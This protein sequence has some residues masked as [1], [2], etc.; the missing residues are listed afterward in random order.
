MNKFKIN[1]AKIVYYIFARVVF[2]L[3]YF[4]GS[5]G[6]QNFL[7]QSL[8][9][10]HCRV[11]HPIGFTWLIS[12][13]DAFRTY[14]QSCEPYTTKF[15]LTNFHS[16]DSFICVGA[17]RGWYPL[18]VGTKNSRTKI[19][20][21]E[22]NSRIFDELAENVKENNLNVELI[23]LAVGEHV[24]RADLFMPLNGNEG[25]AT[26]FPIGGAH[27]NASIVES[28]GVTSLDAYF[29]QRMAGFG[30]GLILMDIEG[31]EMK[32]LNGALG[33][34]QEC[35]PSIILEINPEMLEASGSSAAEIFEFLRRLGYEINWIDERGRLES[36]G[37]DNQLPHLKILPPHSGA[38]YL[39]SIGLDLHI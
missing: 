24:S 23:P 38:N 16:L 32:A 6:V 14:I 26:L 22:C 27:S 36:V 18:L 7:V 19:F 12:S 5:F 35:Q 15:V 4:H 33:V 28:V 34:L 21:F 29:D 9:L 11:R 20:A 1:L 17:N 25:M 2:A 8:P 39:F 31:S 3:G 30:R 13:R 37:M 10:Q